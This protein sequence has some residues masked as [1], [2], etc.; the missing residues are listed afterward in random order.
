MM[1]R[2]RLAGSWYPAEESRLLEL[3]GSGRG[4]GGLVAGVLPHA[5]LMFSARLTRLFFDRLDGSVERLLIVS[6]SHYYALGKGVVVTSSYT[7]AETPL[8]EVAVRPLHIASA[9]EDDSVIAKEHGLEVFLPFAKA[10]GGLEVSFLVL[11][12]A[13]TY[14]SL[15]AM[16]AVLL[17]QLDGRTALVASSDF[18]H[19]GARFGY[20]PYGHRGALEEVRKHDI[21]IAGLLARTEVDSVFPIHEETTICG[22]VPAM[23]TALVAKERGLEG[24]ILGSDDSAS[25]LGE[26]DGDFVSYVAIGWGR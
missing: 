3:T 24:R 8:G 16:E 10:R 19:Y 2:A 13:S 9:I 25:I 20:Q 21:T 4:S 23:A 5:G 15:E 12:R 18:T 14:D 1:R 6:P 17:D 26:G 7:S 11:G 22:I